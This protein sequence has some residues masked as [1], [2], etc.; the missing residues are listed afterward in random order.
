MAVGD[1]GEARA[2]RAIVVAQMAAGQV[3]S[4]VDFVLLLDDN[5][6]PSGVRCPGSARGREDFEHG[7]HHVRDGSGLL[8]AAS[9]TGSDLRAAGRTDGTLFAS[10]SRGLVT[11]HA[12][13]R[14]LCVAVELA[15]GRTYDRHVESP[16]E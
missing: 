14:P 1:T 5:S 13:D 12:D 3:A 7:L 11:V 2:P 9:G 8:Q 4:P 15:S 6:C 10:T 16:A